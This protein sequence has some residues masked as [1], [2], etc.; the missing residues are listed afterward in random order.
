MVRDP[1]IFAR[2]KKSPCIMEL[3]ILLAGFSWPVL[4][5]FP[6]L[7]TDKYSKCRFARMYVG[8]LLRVRRVAHTRSRCSPASP[9][10]KMASGP[11]LKSSVAAATVL[12]AAAASLRAHPQVQVAQAPALRRRRPTTRTR[13]HLRR[14]P[15]VL[16]PPPRHECRLGHTMCS[17]WPTPKSEFRPS[18]L[19]RAIA[20]PT[21]HRL[22][23][24]STVQMIQ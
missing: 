16:R 22:D 5:C 11:R 24:G 4:R 14:S 10:S 21:S 2:T 15:K 19:P 23:S 7:G 6:S 3:I 8:P 18:C 1:A 9:C 12:V 17:A 13:V 20:P